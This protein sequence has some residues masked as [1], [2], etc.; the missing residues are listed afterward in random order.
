MC[1]FLKTKY[2]KLLFSG[3][4]FI[5]CKVTSMISFS[6]LL[7]HFSMIEIVY[8]N[9]YKNALPITISP[10][11][12][13]PLTARNYKGTKR[14]YVGQLLRKKYD[15]IYSNNSVFHSKAEIPNSQYQRLLACSQCHQSFHW[16]L[17]RLQPKGFGHRT[18][19]KW[20]PIKKLN[21]R[22]PYLQ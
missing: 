14:D 21:K 10:D 1:T 19:Q 5:K 7:F 3:L 2:L 4:L 12:L 13:L 11:T 9:H 22:D 20:K 16:K 8:I 15:G 18:L 17:H 6:F